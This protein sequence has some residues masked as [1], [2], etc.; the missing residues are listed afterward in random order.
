MTRSTS[1]SRTGIAVYETPVLSLP[2]FVYG[3]L[4]QEEFI[5]NLLGRPIELI[6]ADL[7]GF[8]SE[9]LGEI[10]FPLLL[11]E[12]GARVRGTI[13]PVLDAA[14]YERLDA[15]GGVGEGLYVRCEVEVQPVSRA[16][17]EADG[18]GGGEGAAGPGGLAL[19]AYVYLASG[20][21]RQRFG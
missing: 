3:K 10:R 21:T 14:D 16:S 19:P 20:K 18:D 6:E 1:D 17:T 4:A 11:P 12:E 2:L 13:T 15:Y 7:V 5:A 9:Q 8:R